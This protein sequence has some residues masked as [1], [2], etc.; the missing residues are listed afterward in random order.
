MLKEKLKGIKNKL[1]AW[2]KEHLG[3]L[4]VQ[5]NEAKERLLFWDLKGESEGLSEVEVNQRRECGAKIHELSSSKCS[6]FGKSQE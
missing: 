6:L 2:N 5:I 4:D 1:K 3:N